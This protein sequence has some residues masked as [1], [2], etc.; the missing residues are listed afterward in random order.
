[1]QF[2]ST[3]NLSSDVLMASMFKVAAM[4]WH[5]YVIEISAGSEKIKSFWKRR[6]KKAKKNLGSCWRNGKGWVLS[7][8]HISVIIITSTQIIPRD[9]PVL[10]VC[11][12]DSMDIQRFMDISHCQRTREICFMRPLSGEKKQQTNP[13]HV[14]LCLLWSW[15]EDI[16]LIRLLFCIVCMTL[17]QH[18][19][20]LKLET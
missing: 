14:F 5:Y 10:T 13:E 8:P 9:T 15:S 4:Q 6:K 18:Y 1:M 11:S 16:S 20:P 3:V 2:L 19:C 12:A 7:S 17:A